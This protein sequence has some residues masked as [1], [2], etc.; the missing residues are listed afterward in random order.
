MEEFRKEL[1]QLINRHSLEN[2]SGTPDFVLADYL[3]KCLQNFN[4]AYRSKE[5][6]FNGEK[7]LNSVG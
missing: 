1:Q 3:V 7:Q 5:I 6:F 2:G 4:D